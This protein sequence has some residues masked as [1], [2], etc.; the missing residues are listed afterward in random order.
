MA[1]C[2]I[3]TGDDGFVTSDASIISY[4]VALLSEV[5]ETVNS[6]NWHPMALSRKGGMKKGYEWG[7]EKAK[8]VW[9]IRFIWGNKNKKK[10]F[11]I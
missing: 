11:Q 9:F 2:V 1:D 6:A 7:E 3:T 10:V 4:L 8:K 5:Y